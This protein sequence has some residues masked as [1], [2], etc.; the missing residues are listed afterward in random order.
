MAHAVHGGKCRLAVLDIRLGA[1]STHGWGHDGGGNYEEAAIR[2]HRQLT[3]EG[4]RPA[5]FNLRRIVEKAPPS[6][7]LAPDTR[8]MFVP[9][10]VLPGTGGA[11]R[12]Q[13]RPFLFALLVPAFSLVGVSA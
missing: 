12:K 11:M 10:E 3:P 9:L 1:C 5:S 6:Y 2:G 8:A 4:L 13:Y 7:S